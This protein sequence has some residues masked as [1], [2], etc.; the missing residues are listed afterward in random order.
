MAAG[1]HST[2]RRACQQGWS[3]GGGWDPGLTWGHLQVGCGGQSRVRFTHWTGARKGL[4]G[5]PP[6]PGG[7]HLP[8]CLLTREEG[9]EACPSHNTKSGERGR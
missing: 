4:D 3:G 1:Q 5:G 8:V 2:K 6:L 9:W 7:G